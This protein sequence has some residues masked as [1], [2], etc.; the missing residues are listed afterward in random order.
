MDMAVY[1][2]IPRQLVTLMNGIVVLYVS[3]KSLV[4]SGFLRAIRGKK[5]D[6]IDKETA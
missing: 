5:T 4:Q 1:T 2:Q 3:A 6:A